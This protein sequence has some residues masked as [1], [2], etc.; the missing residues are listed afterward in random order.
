M[1]PLDLTLSQQMR[2]RRKYGSRAYDEDSKEFRV[3]VDVD[4]ASPRALLAAASRA[5]RRVGS[6]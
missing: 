2:V 5:R 1:G 4:A 3:D 6:P